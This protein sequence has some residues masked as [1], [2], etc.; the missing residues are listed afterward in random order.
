MSLRLHA[1]RIVAWSVT[2]TSVLRHDS[3]GETTSIPAIALHRQS[4]RWVLSHLTSQ[5]HLH[6]GTPPLHNP[7]AEAACFRQV[8]VHRRKDQGLPADVSW[9]CDCGVRH[10]QGCRQ[11]STRRLANS[12][13][14]ASYGSTRP[15]RLRSAFKALN[16]ST[17]H[18]SQLQINY[19]C[20]ALGGPGPLRERP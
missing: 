19:M 2:H 1:P 11:V 9:V 7:S 12:F 13:V 3:V 14:T 8:S 10:R 18:G 4:R 20:V 16:G 17:F 15:S 5:L 6:L